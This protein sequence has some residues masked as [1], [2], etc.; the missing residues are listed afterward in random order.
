MLNLISSLVFQYDS[1]IEHK[2]ILK[3]NFIEQ[4][5]GQFYGRRLRRLQNKLT[6]SKAGGRLVEKLCSKETNV[7][8]TAGA[9]Y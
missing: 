2:I 5:F 4:R 3:K 7:V 1:C 9:V 6:R 8:Q